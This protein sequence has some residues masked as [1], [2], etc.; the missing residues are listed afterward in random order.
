M[1]SSN[2]LLLLPVGLALFLLL[3]GLVGSW[4]TVLGMLLAG[5][6]A[7]VLALQHNEFFTYILENSTSPNPIGSQQ[8]AL[9]FLISWAAL[10]IVIYMFY[11]ILWKPLSLPSQRR[12]EA[13][14][15][16]WTRLL[17]GL[18]GGAFGWGLG[19]VLLLSILSIQP[20]RSGAVLDNGTRRYMEAVNSAGNVTLD[21]VKPWLTDGVSG[22]LG[23]V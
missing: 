23:G 2:P 19:A 17:R 6:V 15:S 1:N 8:S 20:L 3:V 18:L 12:P 9:A 7:L 4:R 21:L 10:F 16:G 22:V 13:P 11:S 5:Y 14:E